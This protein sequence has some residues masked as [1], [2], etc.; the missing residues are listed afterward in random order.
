M[1][2]S[3]EKLNLIKANVKEIVKRK[4]L[5]TVPKIIAISKTFSVNHIIPLLDSG[6]IHFG[7]NKIQ[8]AESKWHDIKNKYKNA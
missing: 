7:E 1:H 4:Q 6:H 2:K 5:K 8:E 3:V